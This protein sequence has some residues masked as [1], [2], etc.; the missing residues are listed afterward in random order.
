[1]EWTTDF[2]LPTSYIDSLTL[3]IERALRENPTG[4]S[5]FELIQWLRESGTL[6]V[7]RDALSD[8][9][10]LFR[11]HFLVFHGLYT[12]RLQLLESKQGVLE[13][14]PIKT[15]LLPYFATETGVQE[16]DPLQDYYLDLSHFTG[17]TEEDVNSLLD[18]F[19]MKFAKSAFGANPLV[20]EDE[21]QAAL[22]VLGL[23]DPVENTDI[24]MAYRRL[25]M[26]HHPDRGGD[27]ETLKEINLAAK[28]L[29]G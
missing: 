13:I 6:P 14:S 7:A 12:L 17:T 24:K 15:R 2:S 1:M 3:A 23:Q 25:A 21:R 10:G 27:E 18:D 26:A 28:T 19:W 9:L 29:L 22:T 20:S 4:L 11:I 16:Q 5:E 8:R